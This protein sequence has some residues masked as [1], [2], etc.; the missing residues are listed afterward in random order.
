MANAVTQRRKGASYIGR[1]G[2][3][4]AILMAANAS[5]RNAPGFVAEG[6]LVLDSTYGELN[7]PASTVASFIASEAPRYKP[8]NYVGNVSATGSLSTLAAAN[9]WTPATTAYAITGQYGFLYT[10]TAFNDELV[11]GMVVDISANNQQNL[12]SLTLT[13]YGMSQ[14]QAVSSTGGVA[15][16]TQGGD[17][18]IINAISLEPAAVDNSGGQKRVRLWLL[19]A[20]AA[21]NGGY[22]YCPMA[23]R[24]R[25]A[26]ATANNLF[27]ESNKPAA[28]ILGSGFVTASSGNGPSVSSWL[29]TRGKIEVDRLLRAFTDTRTKKIAP[30]S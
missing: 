8:A 26:T 18:D 2:A 29:L 3:L 6:A 7:T 24:A 12:P 28:L 10:S 15:V 11:F 19:P 25:Q 21:R 23:I 22:A 9:G 27:Y 30:K 13:M 4:L 14:Q 1:V 16:G 5:G 20:V 17:P